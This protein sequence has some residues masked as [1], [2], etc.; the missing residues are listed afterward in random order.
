MTLLRY[1]YPP[2]PPAYRDAIYFYSGP[3]ATAE[4]GVSL[5]IRADEVILICGKILQPAWCMDTSAFRFV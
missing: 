1:H 4:T 5:R 2:F 3:S